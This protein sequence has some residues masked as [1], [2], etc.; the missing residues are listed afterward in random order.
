[1]NIFIVA[2]FPLLCA[3]YHCNKHLIKMILES[4]QMLCTAKSICDHGGEQVPPASLGVEKTYRNVHKNHPC[5]L[6]V[7]RSRAAFDWLAELALA[8]CARYTKIYGKVHASEA[9]V[10]ALAAASIDNPTGEDFLAKTVVATLPT[11]RGMIRMPLC[12]PPE[13]MVFRPN[14]EPDAILSYRHYYI[15]E[16]AA[17]AKWKERKQPPRWFRKGIRAK[18]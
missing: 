13:C 12:M 9:L 1:M 14:G 11:R 5:S 17:F 4:T 15:L 8:L 2:L 10:R 18:S 3:K 16:K 6:A 7:R